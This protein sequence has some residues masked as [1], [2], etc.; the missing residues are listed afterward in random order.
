[1]LEQSQIPHDLGEGAVIHG[2]LETW[3]QEQ[4]PG[5]ST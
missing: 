1:M 4:E 5:E 3:K 2:L